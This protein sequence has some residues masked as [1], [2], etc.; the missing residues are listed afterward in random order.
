MIW[1]LVGFV[2]GWVVIWGLERLIRRQAR[3]KGSVSAAWL[4][5]QRRQ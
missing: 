1:I 3:D 4:A 5:D 2:G